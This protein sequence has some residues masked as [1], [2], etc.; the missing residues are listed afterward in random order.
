MIGWIKELPEPLVGAVIG[1]AAWFGI[2]YAVLAP[3]A[4]ENDLVR[5]VYPACME[6]LEAEQTRAIDKATERKRSNV[7]NARAEKRR[8]LLT[9]QAEL[10]EV[11]KQLEIYQSMKGA[12]D[13]SG[14]GVFTPNILPPVELPS[15]ADVE[16]MQK[17]VAQGLAALQ[18]PIEVSFPRVPSEEVMKTCMC[19]GL[20]AVAGERTNYAISM[21]SFRLVS[22]TGISSVKQGV[23]E[24]L[25]MKSCGKP[26]WEEY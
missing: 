15:P 6:Q 12:L 4:M 14:L 5:D 11:E 25:R 22:P 16:R 23:A 2:G 21:A 9:R 17:N 26:V 8:E 18:L 10:G 1:G 24:T 20:Q 3:R 7:E 13:S 19:A